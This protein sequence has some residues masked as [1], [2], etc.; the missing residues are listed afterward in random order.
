LDFGASKITILPFGSELD[1]E[2]DLN[3][4]DLL[5]MPLP[6]G[7]ESEAFVRFSLST[8][9]VSYLSSGNP[10]L[11][12]GPKNSAAYDLLSEANAAFAFNS[13]ES[14]PLADLILKIIEN[15]EISK[16]H[17]FNSLK[18]ARS[19]FSLHDQRAKFWSNILEQ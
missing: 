10:I 11:F 6:F 4:M 14:L 5:Y 19:R 1:V 18:L 15:P 7:S 13:L 16:T 8:K 3:E 2:K 17:I 12:H 9:M